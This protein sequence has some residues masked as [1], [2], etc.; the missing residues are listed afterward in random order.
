M[1][2]WIK[3]LLVVR[4]K[5]L[6]DSLDDPEALQQLLKRQRPIFIFEK[7]KVIDAINTLRS[8]KGSLVLVTNEFG[9]VQGFITPLDVFEA[10]ARYLAEAPLYH[11]N[12]LADLSGWVAFRIQYAA[13]LSGRSKTV[14]RNKVIA[15]PSFAGVN[16]SR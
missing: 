14:C 9:N 15:F 1:A 3:S 13:H 6:I 5:E 2:V 12:G 8:S 7:M 4:A 10:I 16:N 11:F